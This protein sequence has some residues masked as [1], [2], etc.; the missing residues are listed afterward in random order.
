VREATL[1]VTPLE[2]VLAATT[3]GVD[4]TAQSDSSPTI[5][6]AETTAPPEPAGTVV[7]MVVSSSQDNPPATAQSAPRNN[8]TLWIGIAVVV[9]LFMVAV[10][11]VEFVR[12][13][14]RG[15]RR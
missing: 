11:A 10:A 6:S 1:I 15:G 8:N 7:A 13:A 14:R 9:Q 4:T 5:V 2:L 3:P 12:R